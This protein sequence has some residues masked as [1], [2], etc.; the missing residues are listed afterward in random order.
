MAAVSRWRRHRHVRGHVW[1][2]RNGVLV[3]M[4]GRQLDDGAVAAMLASIGIQVRDARQSRGWFL[5]ELAERAGVSTSVVCRLELARREPSLNQLINTSA[6][7]GLRFS[8]ILRQAED[9]AFPLG[10]RPW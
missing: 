1:T 7:L 4:D 3:Q 8:G 5:S 9:E 10:D 6:V 2:A